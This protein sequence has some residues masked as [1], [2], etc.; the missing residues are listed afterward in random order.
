MVLMARHGGTSSEGSSPSRGD[1]SRDGAEVPARSQRQGYPARSTPQRS[2]GA[3]VAASSSAIDPIADPGDNR[4]E[5][6]CP[7]REEPIDAL[8][9]SRDGS[10]PGEPGL[11]SGSPR[12]PDRSHE[13]GTPAEPTLTLL[14]P[15]ELSLL[16][17][18]F[19]AAR[20]PDVEVVRSARKPRG[21][22]RGGAAV[23]S[24]RQAGPWS[25]RSKRSSMGRSEQTFLEIRRRRDEGGPLVTAIEILESVQQEGRPP[26][27][28]PVHREAAGSPR[29]RCPPGRDRPPAREDVH[30]GRPARVGRGEGGPVRLP[31]LDPSV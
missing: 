22:S 19:P 1:W 2:S 8:A 6:E 24:C 5:H 27:A 10:V 7:H 12:Q 15:V 13:G 11:V 25:S 31:D 9:V 4:A 14:R 23:P 29:Q 26:V 17:G 21:R 20:R 18:A 16:A 3:Y 30:R 28:R